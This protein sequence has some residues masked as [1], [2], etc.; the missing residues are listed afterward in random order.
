MS[1]NA[2]KKNHINVLGRLFCHL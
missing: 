2:L 1:K